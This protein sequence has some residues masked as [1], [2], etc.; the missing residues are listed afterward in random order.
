MTPDRVVVVGA[1]IGGVRTA[2]AL[3][4]GGFGGDIMIIGAELTEPYD[5]PPLSKQVLAGE[6]NADDIALLG[7]AGWAGERLDGRLGSPAVDL[8]TESKEVLLADGQRIGYDALVI[9]TG[10][11]ARTLTTEAN[12]LVHTVRELRDATALRQRMLG[13][14]PVVVVGGGFIGA[15]VAASAVAL[16]AQAAIVESLPTPFTRVLGPAVG[17]LMTELHESFGVSVL[18]GAAVARVEQLTDGTGIVHLADGRRLAA[19]TVVVGIGCVPNTEWLHSSGLPLDDGVITDQHCAVPGAEDVY[20]IGDVARWY[21]VHDGTHRRVEHW[22]NAVEQAHLVAHNILAPGD[23]RPHTKAPYFW[24]DQY[25]MKIQMAG[26]IEAD[27]RVDLLRCTIPAG[28]RHVAVYSRHGKFSAAV[29]FGW[30]RAI[31]ACRR[32]WERAATVDEVHQQIQGLA[33]K[34]TAVETR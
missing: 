31:A 12:Q 16:G 30:P 20:A 5:K 13:G 29:T 28:D 9:A 24:S 2:Q 7:A 8:D 18:G 26:R 21:D 1:S 6:Q 10:V 11:R 23:L 22:T 25:G 32:S 27:D 4:A 3:R 34:V 17:A 15:E 14:G 19:G 33:T